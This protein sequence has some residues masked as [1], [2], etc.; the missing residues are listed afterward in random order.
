MGYG[1]PR[2]HFTHLLYLYLLPRWAAKEALYK[3]I[4]PYQT[5][6]WKDVELL[7][8]REDSL[9]GI[10][11]IDSNM[12]RLSAKLQAV[13]TSPLCLTI[14]ESAVAYPKTHVSVSHDGGLIV[15]MAVVEGYACSLGGVE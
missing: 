8:I 1:T 7:P 2:V 6:C 3:A 4:Y 5:L 12:S 13:F 14:D 15:A 10:Q 9:H 11:D